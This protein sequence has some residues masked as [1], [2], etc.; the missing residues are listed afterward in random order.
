MLISDKLLQSV[1]RPARYTGGEL[2]M[3]RKDPDAVGLRFAFAFPDTYEVGMSHLG[4]KIIYDVLNRREDTYCER[5][6]APWV[7]ME[8][9]MRREGIP[10]YSLE[11]QTPLDR[12][13]M[14]G[15]TLQY[16]MSYTN[17]LNMLD[18]AGIPIFS[19]DRKNGPV[20]CAG[21]PCAFNPEPLA[22][23]IDL[24][25]IGDGEDILNELAELY[26]KMK[27]E[28]ASREEFIRASASLKGIYVPALYDVKYNP[29]GTVA[30]Y[31]AREGAPERVVKRVVADL[32]AA[33]YPDSVIVP[34][35]DIIHD[36]IMLELF[37]GCSR[38]C[39]FCQA[40]ML[41][42]PVRERK[43][44]TLV[45][46]AQRLIENT[47]YDEISL[48]S[49]STGDYPHLTELIGRLMKLS[50][51][52]GVSLS[53]PSLRI[54]SFMKEYTDP[55]ADMR[56]TSLTFAPE[57][58]TQRLRDVINKGVTEAD[59]FSSAADAFASGYNSVK[60]YFMLGLPTETEADLDGIAALAK[61]CVDLYYAG[62]HQ[63]KGVRVGVSCSSF[64]PKAFTPFQWEAQDT[65]EVLNEKQNYLKGRLRGR[66]L[67]FKWHDNKTSFLEG[68]FARGD[69]RTAEVIYRAW[70]KGAHFD[71]W[72]EQ[73]RFDAW[74]EAFEETGVDPAFYTH[75]V[76]GADEA[77]P[78]EVIDAGIDRRF[79]ALERERAYRG[80]V[81]PDCRQGCRGCGI[82]RLGG[83]LCD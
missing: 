54:D 32:D 23:F 40:G 66:G 47:G 76:R 74:M 10:L 83:G 60:L 28:G 19:A 2:N 26:V 62:P 44:D 13:D 12:F 57:A 58:G 1:Q 43:V 81:T 71:S 21:G 7:D 29:D 11:T 9:V 75:R 16:E 3:V 34:Y 73:F 48:T 20:I 69:R 61:K 4:G 49:L 18:L 25:M 59:L 64:V 72:G 5:V 36:R 15:F 45:S 77:F 38:G 53:L 56:K 50:R 33:A 41:Y 80:E 63:G 55:F 37:R 78:W 68:V 8:Q 14:V 35:I 27:K 46:L 51:E 70:Q 30:A 79:L 17:I 82:N 31:H 52:K 42:R 22:P 6:Y 24:F 67:D 39:R 65:R